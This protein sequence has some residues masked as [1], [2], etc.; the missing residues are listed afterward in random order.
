[1]RPKTTVATVQR[2][3]HIEAHAAIAGMIWILE[4]RQGTP[5]TS[6]AVMMAAIANWTAMRPKR[7]GRYLFI[8]S[9]KISKIILIF[10]FYR[11]I[12]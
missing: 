9:T 11:A 8:A 6:A 5:T 12:L 1:M 2:I 4:N 3:S 7:I 10:I